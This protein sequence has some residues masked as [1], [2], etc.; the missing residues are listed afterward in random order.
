M[1]KKP[2]GVIYAVIGITGIACLL[3]PAKSHHVAV[4]SNLVFSAIVIFCGF[5]A[6]VL[7]TSD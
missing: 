1:E 6:W 7:L 2:L 5:A 3:T 4:I